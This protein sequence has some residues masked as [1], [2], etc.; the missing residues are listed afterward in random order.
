M[1][2]GVLQYNPV[3]GKKKDNIKRV[4]DFLSDVKDALV[5]LPELCFTGYVFKNKK[6][7]EELSEEISGPTIEQLSY[8]S[9]DNNLFL[10]FGIA[11][12]IGERYY[13]SSVLLSPAGNI[14][15]YRKAH[16][17]NTEKVFFNP[18]DSG[19][20]VFEVSING[21]LARVGLLVCFDWIFPEPWRILALKGA[22]IIAHPTNLVLPYCQNAAI[23]R[24]IENRIYI[25]SSNRI[26]YERG[27]RFTGMSQII[28][29]KG[30]ILL[31]LGE[32]VQGVWTVDCNPDEANDK[33]ITEK[34]DVI[35]DRREDL[36][37]L[38]E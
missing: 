37:R 19:F 21:T 27:L 31:R 2:I 6:E 28:S 10:A 9:K 11:E 1:R 26:G 30:E 38:E 15:V 32:D 7:L 8:I 17:F 36:Y 20:H 23:T 22:Q 18:G 35:K 4:R 12:R 3:F 29:P 34:N 33:M 14:K 16:L 5:V 24:A 25:A 13:N